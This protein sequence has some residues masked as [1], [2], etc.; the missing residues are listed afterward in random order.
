MRKSL[1]CLHILCCP[2]LVLH[3]QQRITFAQLPPFE[4][5]VVYA[6][7]FV[8]GWQGKSKYPYV[9]YGHQLQR[10][11]TFTSDMP[12]CKRTRFFMLT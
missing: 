8:E 10:G 12:E 1:L 5:A 6:K 11:E 9:G 7:F 4:H 2:W 3:A